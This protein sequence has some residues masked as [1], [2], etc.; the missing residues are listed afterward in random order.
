MDA[1]QF[2]ANAGF[3]AGSFMPSRTTHGASSS[4]K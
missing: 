3:A 4:P 2:D 1:R